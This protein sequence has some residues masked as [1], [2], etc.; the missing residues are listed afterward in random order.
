MTRKESLLC[1]LQNN[2]ITMCEFI[3]LIRTIMTKEEYLKDPIVR[4]IALEFW[5]RQEFVD[6]ETK[7]G[8]SRWK[9]YVK[10]CSRKPLFTTEDGKEIFE[11]DA[12]WSLFTEADP[13]IKKWVANGPYKMTHS[14]GPVTI[15]GFKIFKYEEAANEYIIQNKPVLS[16][17]EVLD[18]RGWAGTNNGL[19][20]LV[21]QKIRL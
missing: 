2:R 13:L 20:E 16:L 5:V 4:E 15:R 8:D 14:F 1:D 9:E 21:K 11:G 6:P 17:K 19:K 12:Y 7:V 10:A 3:N 18:A